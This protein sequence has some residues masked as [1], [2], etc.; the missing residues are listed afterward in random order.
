MNI[1]DEKTRCAVCGEMIDSAC[2]YADFSDNRCLF[3]CRKDFLDK[4]EGSDRAYFE[5]ARLVV[6]DLLSPEEFED[7]RG[8]LCLVRE[9]GDEFAALDYYSFS[10]E[11][12]DSLRREAL[13]GI[14]NIK[15]VEKFGAADFEIT[16]RMV[17][18]KFSL[19]GEIRFV[20]NDYL[21]YAE[22]MLFMALFNMRAPAVQ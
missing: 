13:T 4:F 14:W 20:F 1:N 18:G 8:E 17:Q 10:C 3:L 15:A 16:E 2:V 11:K 22:E 6:P 7:V 12:K 5:Q 21:G 19:S 9:F